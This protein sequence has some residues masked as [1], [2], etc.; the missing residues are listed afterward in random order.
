MYLVTK[1]IFFNNP[2]TPTTWSKGKTSAQT[3]GDSRAARRWSSFSAPVKLS[4]QLSLN[5]ETP[6][7]Q[8]VRCLTS[9][10]TPHHLTLLLSW[11]VC[12]QL[13]GQGSPCA[14]LPQ[15]GK[16]KPQIPPQLQPL[17]LQPL[18]LH[19]RWLRLLQDPARISCSPFLWFNPV[20]CRSS[21]PF[22]LLILPFL[23]LL[24]KP[25]LS[26]PL[27][28]LSQSL[29]LF[30]SFLFS[31]SSLLLHTLLA[32]TFPHGPHCHHLSSWTSLSLRTSHVQ[33]ELG[34]PWAPSHRRQSRT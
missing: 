3:V 30:I 16:N 11:L 15:Q 33:L 29:L 10:P 4:P 7:M 18:G 17:F 32:P 20:F 8:A 24:L 22:P 14:I 13:H 6:T 31:K 12:W 23:L 5:R 21:F 2:S 9:L 34:G 28:V 1:Y 27:S 26:S 19:P 25:S